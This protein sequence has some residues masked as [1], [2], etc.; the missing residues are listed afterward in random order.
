MSAAAKKPS[1]PLPEGTF[2]SPPLS[3]QEFA[4][5]MAL[6]RESSRAFIQQS[7]QLRDFSWHELGKK[8]QISLFKG[9]KAGSS[10]PYVLLRAVGE[11]AG[12][13]EE[14]AAMHQLGTPDTLA[15]FLEE[16]DDILDLHTLYDI[17][18]DTRA[19]SS[20]YLTSTLQVAVRWMVMKVPTAATAF[21]HP[22]DFCFLETQDYFTDAKE[23][24]G[25]AIS[26]DS[27]PMDSCPPFS[28]ASN[29]VVRG[30]VQ[31][32]G[33]TFIES[34]TQGTV[35]FFLLEHDH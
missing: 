23:R 2:K 3:Q 11:V 8:H 7:E 1:F 35:R 27:M 28:S 26:M 24:R 9:V 22:R 34:A 6:G 31:L 33:Y 14:V 20:R 19:M 21:M 10:S 32:S 16:S 17:T 18:A 4:H 15:Q 13:L 5:L 29:N 25:W 30:K 12:T